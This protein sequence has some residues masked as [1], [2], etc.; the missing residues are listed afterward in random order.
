WPTR[1]IRRWTH[2]RAPY[3][4]NHVGWCRLVSG[5]NLYMLTPELYCI[6]RGTGSASPLERDCQ[7]HPNRSGRRHCHLGQETTQLTSDHEAARRATHFLLS[8]PD[9]FHWQWGA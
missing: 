1:F 2:D 7:L 5:T 6:R 4:E 8:E 9:R 3:F